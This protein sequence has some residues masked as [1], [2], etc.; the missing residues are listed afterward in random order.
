M[1]FISFVQKTSCY[2]GLGSLLA[3]RF[4]GMI[5]TF[6]VFDQKE[7]RLSSGSVDFWIWSTAVSW[8]LFE[9]RPILISWFDLRKT[10]FHVGIVDSALCIEVDDLFDMN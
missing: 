5:L 9:K 8:L 1:S 3:R 10:D 7:R 2:S 6:L 4:H